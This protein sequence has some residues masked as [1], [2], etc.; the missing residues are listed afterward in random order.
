MIYYN[1]HIKYI[2][3]SSLLVNY[4]GSTGFGDDFIHSLPGHIGDNDVKDV[5]VFPFD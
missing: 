4:R 5:Q 1:S 3:D 2:P